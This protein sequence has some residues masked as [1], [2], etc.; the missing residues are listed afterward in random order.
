[1]RGAGI[2]TLDLFTDLGVVLVVSTIANTRPGRGRVWWLN[3][4]MA[5]VVVSTCW[6]AFLLTRQDC[7]NLAPLLQCSAACGNQEAESLTE[8]LLNL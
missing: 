3:A 7:K 5:V 2:L 8:V 6:S 4:A 1:M